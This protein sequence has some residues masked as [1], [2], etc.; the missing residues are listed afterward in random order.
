MFQSLNDLVLITQAVAPVSASSVTTTVAVDMQG[1]EGVLFIL[2]VGVMTS[3]GTI[4][5]KVQSGTTATPTTDISGAALSAIAD[6]GGSKIYAVDVKVQ[7]MLAAQST[8]RYMRFLVTPATQASVVAATAIRYRKNGALP[9]TT[10][11][12]EIV[13]V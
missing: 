8:H 13:S 4:N 3:G 7:T 2:N 11:F 5:A 9:P 1:W 10:A 6:T 12:T